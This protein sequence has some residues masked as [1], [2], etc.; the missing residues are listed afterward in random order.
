MVTCADC[1]KSFRPVDPTHRVCAEAAP[2]RVLPSLLAGPATVGAD[3]VEDMDHVRPTRVGRCAG[4]GGRGSADRA[5]ARLVVIEL[6]GRDADMMDAVRFG[7]LRNRLL[8]A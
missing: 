2:L 3:R 6:G 8:P 1:G 4:V 5:I 7:H